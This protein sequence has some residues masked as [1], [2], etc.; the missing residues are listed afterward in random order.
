MGV[1][2]TLQF[3]LAM[4]ALQSFSLLVAISAVTDR[5]TPFL[6][7]FME[8]WLVYPIVGS[9]LAILP[10]A[11]LMGAAFPIGLHLWASSS[12]RPQGT[13]GGHP[14][15]S[16]IARRIGVFYS[17]NVAGSILGSLVAGFLLLP[18]V[19]SRWSIAVL[20]TLSFGAGLLLLFASEGRRST[21]V[22]AG[23]VAALVFS[24]AVWRSP[25]PFDQFVA[26]RY[27]RQRIV[28]QEEGVEAT[29][30]VHARGDALTLSLNGN[31]QA[32]TGGMANGHR[33]IG[34]IPMLIHPEAR[35]ALVIGLG[36][37]ATAGAVSLHDG[38]EV[39]VVEL[40]GAV[41]RGAA[42]FEAVNSRVLSRPNVRLRVDDGR[43]YLL[44]TPRKYDVITADLI[45]PI[46]AGSGNLYSAEYFG[47]LRKA[48]NPGGLVLQWIAGTRAEYSMIARTFLSVFPHA[49]AWGDG[50]LFIGSVEP[51]ALRRRDFEWKLQVPGRAAALRETGM[52]TFE[53]LL[54][55]YKAGPEE[56]RAFIGPGPLL[57]DD[58]P[59][60]EYFLSLPRQGDV[61]LGA[62]EGDVSR[63]VV[64]D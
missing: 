61:D 17:I 4:T 60:V 57:T 41:V 44:L 1:L 8:A 34:H 51:L 42:F 33:M 16:Q 56:L 37:G 43:N 38:V 20:A 45:L 6:S 28:W 52:E 47:L 5:V 64:I 32:S 30:V 62:L 19:G 50:T 24:V 15:V 25:D 29:V 3:A 31:H 53:K 54:A 22:L 23:V 55:L 48:L 2:A 9:V 49:T 46:Y 27:P 40:A 21:R 10:S 59:Q 58:R 35:S 7:R 11:L 39:D 63:H 18:R 12:E 14:Q 26:Q 13:R 36:G